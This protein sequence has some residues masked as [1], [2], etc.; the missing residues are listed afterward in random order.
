MAQ[1][2][3]FKTDPF[4]L[5]RTTLAQSWKRDY[6]AWLWEQRCGK[7]KLLLD[8][9]AIAF[10]SKRI[11]ALV[12]TAPSGVHVNWIEREL[13]KHVGVP[14]AA[15]LWDSRKALAARTKAEKTGAP[16][17]YTDRFKAFVQGNRDKLLVFAHNIDSVN[18]PYGAAVVK[19]LLSNRK[20]MWGLDEAD[21]LTDPTSNRSSTILSLS[22]LAVMK[23]VL[24]GT[25]G[26]GGPFAYYAPYA[27]LKRD[28]WTHGSLALRNVTVFKRYF[29]EFEEKQFQR[30]GGGAP[31]TRGVFVVAKDAAGKKKYRNLDRFHELVDPHTSRVKQADVYPSLPRV[32]VNTEFLMLSD[33]QHRMY[34]TLAKEHAV[35]TDGGK[36]VDGSL[37]A[38]RSMRLHQIACGYVG[39]SAD[40]PAEVIPGPQPRLDALVRAMANVGDDEKG[41][42]WT[43][44]QLDQKLVVAKLRSLGI[45]CR[46]YDGMTPEREREA[47]KRLFLDGSVTDCR[48]I[49][50]NTQ[51]MSRGHDL[52]RGN[53]EIFYSFT[54]R[55][56]H[57]SQARERLMGPNQTRPV[58]RTH[59]IAHGTVD[60]TIARAYQHDQE[61]A[62]A[63]HGDARTAL[64]I[65]HTW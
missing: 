49:V 48:W 34:Q 21:D 51:A 46:A 10:L 47:A 44:F 6:F 23:R 33:Q 18:T 13:P 12:I 36:T 9:A 37:A 4:P 22:D 3:Q 25:L 35:V 32:T 5:Q 2:Y 50:A 31:N 20:A 42:I 45:A 41:I 65:D 43:A 59:L 11:D 1:P 56:M 7:S 26:A 61:I 60:A 64:Q 52:S 19:Y 58:F 14:T 17:A 24:S 57:Y 27:F 40:E 30:A 39:I 53:H 28:F 29:A 54:R 55:L 38:V 16:N 15:W 63:L 62:D 8:N